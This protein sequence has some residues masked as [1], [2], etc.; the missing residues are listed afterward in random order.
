MFRLKS[1]RS[2]PEFKILNLAAGE[3]G[4][5]VKPNLRVRATVGGI[6]GLLVGLVVAFSVEFV[7]RG[8]QSRR[9]DSIVDS[10]RVT[11][12]RDEILVDIPARNTLR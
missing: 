10:Y 11:A 8:S 2:R 4:E 7:S 3:H 12:D 9:L 6:L 5:S 1:R